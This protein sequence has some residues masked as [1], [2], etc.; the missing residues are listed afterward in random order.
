ML[1]VFTNTMGCTFRDLYHA[2]SKIPLVLSR[3][4]NA[5]APRNYKHTNTPTDAVRD[6]ALAKVNYQPR[7]QPRGVKKKH[8][9]LDSTQLALGRLTR[10][11]TQAGALST[12]L[13]TQGTNTSTVA[14]KHTHTYTHTTHT[15][16]TH[17]HTRRPT[18]PVA[19]VWHLR[20][21]RNG[22]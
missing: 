8:T 17:E 11:R 4:A 1:S 3:S 21:Q 10:T 6:V 13:R 9:Q 12:R 14:D 2:H 5:L 22:Q 15:Q 20:M 7:G 16:I 18:P 19:V